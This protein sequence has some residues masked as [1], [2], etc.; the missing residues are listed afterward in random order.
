MSLTGMRDRPE[1]I[2]P[3]LACLGYSRIGHPPPF[4]PAQLGRVETLAAFSCLCECVVV[5]HVYPCGGVDASCCLP[6]EAPSFWT[7]TTE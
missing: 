6:V 7:V 3:G 2:W 1:S 4:P 5:A